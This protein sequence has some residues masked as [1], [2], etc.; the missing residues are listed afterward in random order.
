[1]VYWYIGILETQPPARL[2]SADTVGPSRGSLGRSGSSGPFGGSLGTPG[3]WEGGLE[4]VLAKAQR[5]QTK[6]YNTI[7]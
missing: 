1:M 4:E 5:I 2:G 3:R 7:Q 6:Q